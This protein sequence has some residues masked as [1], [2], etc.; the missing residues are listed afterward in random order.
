MKALVLGMGMS[1][2]SASV[3][4][5][6]A[7][8]SVSIFDDNRDVLKSFENTYSLYDQFEKYDIA[9][10]SPG[11]PAT[12]PVVLK[13][14]ADGVETIGEMELAGRY[15][16]KEKVIAVTGTNGK[17]TTVSIIA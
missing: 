7:G 2:V 5:K 4:L 10:L 15:V 13:L 3:F 11:V 8:Y 17:S 9:I 1:G 12:H 14:A 16:T 6:K